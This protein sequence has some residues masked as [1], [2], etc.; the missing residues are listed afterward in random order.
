VD[1]IATPLGPLRA[2]VRAVRNRGPLH[3]RMAE[4]ALAYWLLN[5]HAKAQ[6]DL[7]RARQFDPSIPNWEKRVREFE[8]LF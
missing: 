7:D 8:K 2:W 3:D 4:R 5:E 1:K 6:R